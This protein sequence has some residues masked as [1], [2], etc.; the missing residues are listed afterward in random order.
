MLSSPPA[1]CYL[2]VLPFHFYMHFYKLIKKK[3]KIIRSI[4]YE[5][6]VIVLGMPVLNDKN[7]NTHNSKALMFIM[8]VHTD[9]IYALFINSTGYYLAF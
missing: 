1:H 7:M 8:I 3:K 4:G 5:L 2:L 6:Y 9:V